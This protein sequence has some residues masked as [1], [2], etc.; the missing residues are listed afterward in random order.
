MIA[1]KQAISNRLGGAILEDE[2]TIVT[3]HCIADGGFNA[4]ACRPSRKNKALDGAAS[5]NLI[6]IRLEEPAVSVLVENHVGGL[7]LEL[8]N[9]VG[10]PRIANQN[11][12]CRSMRRRCFRTCA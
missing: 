6:Q 2:A 10:V 1:A 4:H 3:K 9:Y 11:T 7:G 8:G 12:T 5:K